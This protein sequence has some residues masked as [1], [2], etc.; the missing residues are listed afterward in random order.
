M[1]N[2][3]TI[4]DQ[5]ELEYKHLDE[6][7]KN[8]TY[9]TR[10]I[11][12]FNSFNRSAVSANDVRT[13]IDTYTQLYSTIVSHIEFLYER[14]NIHRRRP[15]LPRQPESTS[16]EGNF[17]FINGRY[18]NIDSLDNVNS[19]LPTQTPTESE[20]TNLNQNQREQD[21]FGDVE[22]SGST[23]PISPPSSSQPN[24][25]RL[26]QVQPQVSIN[27]ASLSPPQYTSFGTGT[28]NNY[29][30]N[31]P[32]S[33]P[34]THFRHP[35]QQP[36]RLQ[37]LEPP[38]A[39]HF[40]QG[41]NGLRN[42]T[43]L[44]DTSFNS[45][46]AQANQIATNRRIYNSNRRNRTPIFENLTNEI[47]RNFSEPVIVSA[48]PQQIREATTTL[49]FSE[50]IDPMNTQCPISLERFRP[51]TIVTQINH[52]R[53]AFLPGSF[54][55]WFASNVRCPICRYDIRT[56]VTAANS[57]YT[58]NDNNN[59]NQTIIQDYSSIPAAAGAGASPSM[60][61]IQPLRTQPL[62]SFS[63]RALSPNP[64]ST[65]TP[66][67]EVIGEGINYQADL[68]S[69]PNV[70]HT[71]ES[72]VDDTETT[73]LVNQDLDNEENGS[74][75][76]TTEEDTNGLPDPDTDNSSDS[77]YPSLRQAPPPPEPQPT[78]THSFRNISPPF[79]N[80]EAQETV[81]NLLSDA[82]RGVLNI[83]SPNNG[84]TPSSPGLGSFGSASTAAAMGANIFNNIMNNNIDNLSID[85]SRNTV[86]FE[87]TIY[88]ASWN[89][90]L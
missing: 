24:N 57:D 50:I 70:D 56:H 23:P 26:F 9:L 76:N 4:Y 27:T 61:L 78:T 32:D 62:T 39:N 81:E 6:I 79:L 69:L 84:R 15:S 52:C 55:T 35:P 16:V 73:P 43:H 2:L 33:P 38:L 60:P 3:E 65:T 20:N 54:Q 71:I 18:Y 31:S 8:V 25:S 41:P 42:N 28:E 1:N 34:R 90:R 82:I 63:S 67:L 45:L 53:H 58:E 14:T 40:V 74:F 46:M 64:H 87:T 13:L 48:N 72:N 19:D 10:R 21:A 29:F 51:N 44:S 11:G 7:R 36:H 83:D 30:N 86:R 49:R 89:A 59:I 22:S 37:S 66:G 88:D 80:S 68:D 47:F 77:E 5:I 75:L 85:P 17:A 12:G